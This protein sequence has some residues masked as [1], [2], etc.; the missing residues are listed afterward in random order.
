MSLRLATAV[1]VSVLALSAGAVLSQGT[2]QGAA[3]LTAT[4][5]TYFGSTP[6]VVN[7]VPE[8]AGYAVT[9]D[10]TPLFAMI[11][12]EAGAKVS[13]TAHRLLVTDNG[14]G[15]WTVVQDQPIDF[16]LSIPGMIEMR[17]AA[18]ELLCEGIFDT[19]LK[20]FAENVCSIANLVVDQTV[21]DPMGQTSETNS[22]SATIDF[23]ST[24][25]ANPA[26][27]VD[28]TLAY[29]GTAITQDMTMPLAPG[30]PPLP[31]RLALEAYSA[32]GEI[33]GYRAEVVLDALAWF[34]ANP[35]PDAMMSARGQMRDILSGGLPIWE[36]IDFGI[37]GNGMTVETPIGPVTA[38]ELEIT[39]ALAGAVEN[40]L[41]RESIGVSG[42]KLPEGVLPP[43]LEPLLPVDALID[44]ALEGYDAVGAARVLLGLFDLA[45]GS[46]PGPE[47]EGQLL[48]A[49]LPSGS[50]DIVF[51]AGLLGN[52][53]YEI[54]WEGRISAGPMAMP[55]GTGRV[56]MAGFD[57]TMGLVDSLPQEMKDQALPVMG[58][59]RGI[60]QV[61]ADGSLL[62]EIDA[63]KPGTFKVNGMDLMGMQ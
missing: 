33:T 26:G 21:T 42:L 17:V 49:L 43:F 35:N 40:G 4:F 5:Q 30:E 63:T 27:G 58:M 54:E 53:T 56:T 13:M 14:D 20:V 44:F 29:S 61:Q 16:A 62:W 41:L 32:D 36:M 19:A 24:A 15:T 18:D 52:R 39:V 48:T 9:L 37:L 34:V 23:E 45:P 55:T 22:R 59:A 31:V 2:P 8:G 7:V 51:G 46:R 6:G 57:D 10:A 1:S 25:R 12:A 50:V 47:F 38:D 3:E 60:A 11:P 28:Q